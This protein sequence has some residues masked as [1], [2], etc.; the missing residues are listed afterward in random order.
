MEFISLYSLVDNLPVFSSN[1]LQ[2]GEVIPAHLQKQ[3]SRWVKS[4]KLIQL[5]R[6]LYTLAEPYRKENPHPFTIANQLV[7][8]S[9]VSLQSALAYYN[10]I[11]EDV[12]NVTSVTSRK[13]TGVYTTPIGNFTY[14]SVQMAW[15]TGFRLYEVT[16]T[17]KAFLARPEKALLDLIYLTPNGEEPAFL[18]TLR[19]QNINTL[20]FN[21]LQGFVQDLGK[22]KL[23]KAVDNLIR[24]ASEN[25]YQ[26]L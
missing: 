6:G 25:T 15:F 2:V 13:R 9:Y 19:L 5:R 8:P 17:Q 24:L 1:L 21:W 22:H 16:N 7:A 3:L 10:L 23:I 20:D 4:G 26:T 14:H 11:P 12:P 18:D